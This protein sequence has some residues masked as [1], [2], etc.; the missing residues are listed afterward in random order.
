VQLSVYFNIHQFRDKQHSIDWSDIKSEYF[1][2]DSQKATEFLSDGPLGRARPPVVRSVIIGL[3]KDLV[4]ER[5]SRNERE[6]QFA[7]LKA[8]LML[9]PTLAQSIMAEKLP[10][11]VQNVTDAMFDLVIRYLSRFDEAWKLVGTSSQMRAISYVQ[12]G[13]ADKMFRFI[14]HALKVPA[15]REYATERIVD[16]DADMLARLISTHL[17]RIYVGPAI[18]RLATSGS[19]RASEARLVELILP[20]APLLSPD[21]IGRVIEAFH[22]NEQISWAGDV[23]DLLK[24]LLAATQSIAAASQSHWYRLYKTLLSHKYYENGHGRDL[25]EMLE[26]QF[27]FA[28][29]L[30]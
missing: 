28:P 23:A 18:D 12:N 14:P 26:R 3:T 7:A 21:D 25:R 19:F 4:N 6:R 20:L 2:H 29:V 8:A 13:P 16:L 9:Y 27:A 24:D 17:D 5:R 10:A 15:L 1:P 22:E 11:I 30:S